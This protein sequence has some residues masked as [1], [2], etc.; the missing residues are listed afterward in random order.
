MATSA[1]PRFASVL[2]IDFIREVIDYD[3]KT[4]VML[5]KH[6]SWQSARWNSRYS[7]HPVGTPHD[8]GYTSTR[9]SR[10]NQ[11]LHR[12]AW[13]L[14][15]GEWPA[16]KIDHKNGIRTDNRI[17]NLRLAN[18][19]QNSANQKMRVDNT[20]GHKGVSWNRRDSLWEANIDINNERTRLGRFTDILEARDAYRAASLRL[21]G[22]FSRF[23]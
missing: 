6:R 19:G 1:M 21:H 9:L 10:S 18:D 8:N 5:W 20:S 16:I 22:Q 2:N 3:P 12:I 14:A 23:E 7:G 17:S 11:Y 13:L 15:Y 4:G